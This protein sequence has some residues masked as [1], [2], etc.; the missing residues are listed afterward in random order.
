MIEFM[1]FGITVALLLNFVALMLIKQ[2]I[3]LK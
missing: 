1:L 2:T 3:L